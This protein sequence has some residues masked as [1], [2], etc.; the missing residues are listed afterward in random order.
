MTTPAETALLLLLAAC[1]ALSGCS[2]IAPIAAGAA[3][4]AI[5]CRV[6]EQTPGFSSMRCEP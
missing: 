5:T 1:L 4:D 6:V 2:A 3:V